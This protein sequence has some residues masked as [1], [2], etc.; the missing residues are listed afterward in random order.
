MLWSS[1]VLA[2]LGN[3][4]KQLVFMYFIFKDIQTDLWKVIIMQCLPPPE[5]LFHLT[6]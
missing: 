6:F 5:Y 1:G 4:Q 2:V 3:Y